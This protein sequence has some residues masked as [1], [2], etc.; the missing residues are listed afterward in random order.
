MSYSPPPQ[1]NDAHMLLDMM[2]MQFSWLE[3]EMNMLRQMIRQ[4]STTA[5]HP[6]TFASLRGV[7]QGVVVS[8]SD[9]KTSRLT[10]PEGLL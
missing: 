4:T 3:R 9:F 5:E 8:E 6:R 1:E 2:Q 10:I 7:W